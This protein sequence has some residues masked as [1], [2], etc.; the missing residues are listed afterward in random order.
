MTPSLRSLY[1]L[2]LFF[3][4]LALVPAGAHLMELANKMRLPAA[5]Y[6]TVQ[7][8]YR[9]WSFAGI[10]VIAALVSTLLLVLALR[11]QAWSFY[12]ALVAV[13]CVVLT[14]VVFWSLTFPVNRQTHNW[15]MLPENWIELRA[16]WEYS[17]AASAVLTIIAIVALIVSLLRHP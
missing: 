12:P 14:Q 13:V 5:D 7:Q 10:L 6:R 9:G 2:S 4:A 3:T 11:G 15:T 1:F 17:H 8:I 16:R